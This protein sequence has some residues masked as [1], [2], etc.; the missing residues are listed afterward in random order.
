MKYLCSYLV[1]N[2]LVFPVYNC[3]RGDSTQVTHIRTVCHNIGYTDMVDSLPLNTYFITAYFTF[4]S[5]VSNY[6]ERR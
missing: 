5:K 2:L 4:I 6:F 1:V 3:V